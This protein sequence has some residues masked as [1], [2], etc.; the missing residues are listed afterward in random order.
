MA[1]DVDEVGAEG[2][3][4]VQARAGDEED[5][6]SVG[7]GG[8]ARREVD[9]GAQGLLGDGVVRVGVGEARVVDTGNVGGVVEVGEAVAGVGWGDD[10][11]G[12][13]VGFV[14]VVDHSVGVLAGHDV[15]VRLADDLVPEGA[16]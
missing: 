11:V 15:L 5:D 3:V 1:D 8:E 12:Y 14:N 7:G 9:G 6:L 2:F 16:T 4:S 10:G 13:S